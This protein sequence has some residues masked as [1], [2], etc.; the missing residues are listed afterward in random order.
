MSGTP[1]LFNR[2]DFYRCL[3]CAICTGSCPAARV[4]EGFNPREYILK[5]ILY[6]EQEELLKSDMIWCC[7]T[8]Q[9]CQERC[10]HGIDISGFLIHIMNLAAERG[11]LPEEILKEIRL[12]A[13]TG[14]SIKSTA[15]TVR[16]REELGL[17]ALEQPDTEEIR[18]ILRE[19][20]L[21]GM[22]DQK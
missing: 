21:K 11:N 12:I 14:R 15:H 8:C 10:P 6:G 7:T 9:I 17:K 4:I 5:Y 16:V 20:G 2:K 1:E 3:Q 19:A 13:E 18:N 22:L